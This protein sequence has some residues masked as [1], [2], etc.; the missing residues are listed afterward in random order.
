LAEVALAHKINNAVEASY[1][2]GDMIERRYE[3]MSDW[4]AFL[5]SKTRTGKIIKLGK[6]V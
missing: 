6:Y 3:M 5:A 2:R 4:S 1:R